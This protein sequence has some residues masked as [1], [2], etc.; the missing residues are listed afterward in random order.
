VRP[1]VLE[2]LTAP[3][4]G[5]R[6]ALASIA[7][8]HEGDVV[9]GAARSPEHGLFPIRDSILDLLPDGVGPRTLGQL[10]NELGLT[11][12]VYEWPWRANSLSLLSHEW[13]PFQRERAIFDQLLGR[14]EGTLWLDLAA[15]TA[16][17]GR[18]LAPRLFSEGGE[19][20]SLDFAWPMLRRARLAAQ[21]EGQKNLSFVRARAEALPFASGTLD[22][23]VCGG[24]L[25]EFG[26]TGVAAAL[27]EV[28]R[29]LRPGGTGLFMHL[30][31]AGGGLD[32]AFQRYVARPGGIAFWSRAETDSLFQSAGLQVEESRDIGVVG[33]TRVMKVRD[34]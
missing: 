24:S 9:H 21:G 12:R 30:L 1:S 3:G 13:L 22:G 32:A 25:N 8:E 2:Q 31:A 33:F 20:V 10:S 19:V 23:V 11:A 4:G 28:A 14:V 34:D 15:S 29:A 18:W 17:Y 16:L 5:P 26:A 7:D 6:L 27:Q